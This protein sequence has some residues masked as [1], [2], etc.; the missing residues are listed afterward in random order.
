MEYVEL[1]SE[2]LVKTELDSS[3]SR[4]VI[5]E[6]VDLLVAEHEIRIVHRHQILEEIVK[7]EKAFSTGIGNGVA[8]PHARLAF[9]KEPVTALGI[10]K[11]GIDFKAIDGQAVKIVI[12][13]LTPSDKH[14]SHLRIISDIAK[15]MSKK[16][17]PE[18]IAAATDPAEVVSIIEIESE[19]RE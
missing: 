7:R 14:D 5:E 4:E 12:L 8:V 2:D 9:L 3:T 18:R 19:N 11:Q 10:S 17:L 1:I 16:G 15:L 6:L 13:L